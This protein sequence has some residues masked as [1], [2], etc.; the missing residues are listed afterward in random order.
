MLADREAFRALLR[1]PKKLD[2]PRDPEAELDPKKTLAR[3]LVE[4]GARSS[5]LADLYAFFGVNVHTEA[6]RGMLAFHRFRLELADAIRTVARPP[7]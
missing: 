3:I 7:R 6:L 5:K 4:A 2:L 1:S